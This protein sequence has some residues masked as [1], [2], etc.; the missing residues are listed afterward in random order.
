MQRLVNSDGRQP[1]W[2]A[3][4]EVSQLEYLRRSMQ[5]F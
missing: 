1:A 5:E 3:G 4:F 2:R